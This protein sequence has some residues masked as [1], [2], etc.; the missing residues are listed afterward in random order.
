MTDPDRNP[1]SP[2]EIREAWASLPQDVRN[3][4]LRQIVHD[5]PATTGAVLVEVDVCAETADE[6]NVVIELT[7]GHMYGYSWVARPPGASLH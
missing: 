1:Q 5:E 6:M 2:E 4:L 7:T 3:H